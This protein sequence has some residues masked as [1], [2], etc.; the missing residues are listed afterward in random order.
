[1]KTLDQYLNECQDDTPEENYKLALELTVRDLSFA[2]MDSQKKLE[3]LEN[4]N[5]DITQIC[6][7]QGEKLKKLENKID[8]LY[9]AMANEHDYLNL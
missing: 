7:L 2:V 6:F 3:E 5:D 1:M 4:A 9:N 8:S